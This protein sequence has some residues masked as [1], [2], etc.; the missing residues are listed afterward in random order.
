VA[1]GG[2]VAQA[3]KATT[4]VAARRISMLRTARIEQAFPPAQ[5]APM[6][7]RR[8]PRA[9]GGC[10]RVRGL[11]GTLVHMADAD[12]FELQRF[13]EAQDRVFGSVTAELAAGLKTSH[14][15]WFVFPQLKALGRSSTALRY[16]IGSLD[17]ARA[18]WRH[19]VLGARLKACGHLLLALPAGRS[20][21]QVFGSIDTL[22]LRSCLTLF[23]RAAPE[24]PL[25]AAL[26]DRFYA[27]ER[28]AAT[29]ALT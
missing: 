23:E 24:E 25:F 7:R 15:M 4:A 12:P 6:V 17:E 9:Y 29:L 13:V 18:Y 3:P 22:K 20:A 1:A 14:W 10:T 19:P 11:R 5:V 28:D 8:R 2:G 26:L 21:L 27:G 16:G